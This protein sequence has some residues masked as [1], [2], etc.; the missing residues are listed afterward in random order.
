VEVRFKSERGG[1]ASEIC[2]LGL[3]IVLSMGAAVKST[4]VFLEF[5]V[6][7]LGWLKPNLFWG[8]LFLSCLLNQ[9][10]LI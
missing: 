7:R 1:C 9:F 3:P 10:K 4:A 2:E 5:S 6:T 8:D